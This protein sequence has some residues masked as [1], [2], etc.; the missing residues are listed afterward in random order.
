MDRCWF[1]INFFRHSSPLN[2]QN[3]EI[4][5]VLDRPDPRRPCGAISFSI[6]AVARSQIDL[7]KGDPKNVDFKNV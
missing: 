5:L 4:P 2:R 6:G 3:P 7:K 1:E